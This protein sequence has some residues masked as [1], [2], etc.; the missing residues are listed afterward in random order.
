LKINQI[1]KEYRRQDQI[2]ENIE[3]QD[4]FPNFIQELFEILKTKK[5]I[6]KEEK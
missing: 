6:S 1:K 2:V 5:N 3:D 4:D